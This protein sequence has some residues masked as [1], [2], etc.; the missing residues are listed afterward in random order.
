MKGYDIIFLQETHCCNYSDSKLWEKEWGGACFWSFGGTR[1]RGTAVLCRDGLSFSKSLFYYDAMGRLVVLDI[2][3]Y[4]QAYRLINVYAPNK[5]AERVQWFNDLH[6]WFIDDKIIIFGGDFNCV[7]NKNTDK[8]GGND[9]YGDVGASV[10]YSLRNNYRLVD[11]Y[12]VRFP[13]DVATSWSSADGSVACRLD[14]LYVSTSLKPYLAACMIPCVFSDHSAVEISFA[15]QNSLQ[16]GPS[17]W[18]CNVKILADSDLCADLE[19]VC[20]DC[21]QAEIKD[22]EW[23]ENCKT[24]FKRLIVLH[25]CRLAQIYRSNLNAL[26]AELRD[27]QLKSLHSPG[28]N[29]EQIK[30]IKSNIADMLQE[31]FDGS[32]IRSRAKYL[33]TEETPSTYFLRREKQNAAKSTITELSIDGNKID[34]PADILQACRNFYCDLYSAEPVVHADMN[35]MLGRVNGLS[36][37]LTA[38][39]GKVTVDECVAAINSMENNKTPGMDGL[40]KE[41]YAKFFHLFG[42]GFVDMINNCFDTGILPPSQRHGLITLACKDADNAQLLTNW[43]PISLL[44]VDYKILAKVLSKRL[45]SALPDCVHQDQ[46]CA[47]PGRSIQDNLNLFR[48]VVDFANEHDVEA[49]IVSYDQAKA[50]DRVS[51]EYLFNV[52]RAFGFNENFVSWVALLYRD[53]SSSVIVNGFISSAFSVMRS[54]RQGCP[55]SALLYVLCIEPLAIAIR[56]D[57]RIRGLTLP[58]SRERVRLALYADDTNSFIGNVCEIDATLEWFQV[59]SRASGAKL[60]ENKC[61]GLWLGAWRNRT[62]QPCGFAWSDTLKINGVYFGVNSVFQNCSMLKLKVDKMCDAYRSRHLTLLGRA[63]ICNVVI[64]AQL[65]YVAAVV[66]LPDSIITEINR[67]IFAFIWTGKFEAVSRRTL[68]S[69][70]KQGGLG[71]VHIK[72]TIDS[73][74]CAHLY[75]LITGSEAKWKFFAV[76]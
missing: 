62:D 23:W 42:P 69:H 19:D 63:C 22:A 48:D 38:C 51:H 66:L 7:D 25:S 24:R 5:H 56:Q 76:Y 73:L 43:R 54:I 37:S 1:A 47:I 36:S 13:H 15:V 41:F 74:R 2:K 44:N 61:K 8:V 64:C 52:L 40:P 34:N 3:L 18:K 32:K 50:F 71:V 26:E 60:N 57:P 11:S 65:W 75:K 17:Y 12:R 59:Y 72:H 14:R 39:D 9:A 45:S 10:L 29:A 58:G 16:K 67:K 20:M 6:R 68:T 28:S 33:D 55:L 4:D 70:P 31:K 27:L 21:M 35:D 49:A 46:T 30:I 53:V